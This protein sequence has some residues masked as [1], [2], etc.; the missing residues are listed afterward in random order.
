MKQKIHPKYGKAIVKCAC[1][2]IFETQST[3]PELLT[4]ICSRCHPIYTGKKKM[5]DSTKRVDKFMK[6]MEKKEKLAVGKKKRTEARKAK[7]KEKEKSA[8]AAGKENA[9]KKRKKTIVN[10]Q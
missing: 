1:G 5:I 7:M 8:P 3:K 9:E 4:E 6:R 2:A 10:R